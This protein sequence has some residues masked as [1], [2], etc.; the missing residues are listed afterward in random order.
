MGVYGA[1]NWTLLK[2][3]QKYLES[4]RTWCWRRIEISWANCVRNEE[5]LGRVE[6]ERNIL[7]TE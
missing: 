5:I 6:E 1:E 3:Y 4:F 7:H 2:V